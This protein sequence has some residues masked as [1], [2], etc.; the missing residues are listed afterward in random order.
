MTSIR[1]FG[2]LA[3][4]SVLALGAS[5]AQAA[6]PDHLYQLNGSLADEMGGPALVAN[7]GSL[8]G[9]SYVFGANQGLSLSNVLGSEYSIDFVF[10]FDT[11]SGYRKLVDFKDQSSDHGLYVLNAQLNFYPVVTGSDLIDGGAWAHATLTRDASG[12]VTGYLNGV[13]QWQFDDSSTQRATFSAAGNIAKFFID[14]SATSGE[15]SAGQVDYI[16]TYS[17]ALSAAEV[18]QISSPVP[19]PASYALMLAGVAALGLWSRRRMG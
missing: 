19:E 8:S 10:T 13:A 12:T 2:A 9:G 5:L 17:R 11:L 1:R 7:G 15:A 6:T 14:D 4:A 3:L 18:A 16:A